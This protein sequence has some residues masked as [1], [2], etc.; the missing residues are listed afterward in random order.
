MTM[1]LSIRIPGRLKLQKS[2]DNSGRPESKILI[3]CLSFYFGGV[4]SKILTKGLSLKF[5]IRVAKLKRTV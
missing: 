4:L 5:R 1:T 2:D 3:N